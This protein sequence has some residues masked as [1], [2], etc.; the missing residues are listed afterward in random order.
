MTHKPRIMVL[1]LQ[2]VVYT[3]IF[4]ILA[5]VLILLLF[6]M[7]RPE[8]EEYARTPVTTEKYT[9]G[10]YTS[11]LSLGDVVLDVEVTV[12]ADHINA[13]TLNN[14]SETVTTMYP[15]VEPAVEKLE[16]Q[17]LRDQSTEHITWDDNGKYTAQVLLGAIEKALQIAELR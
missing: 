17:I 2:E 5:I 12:D 6:L 11:S 3:G 13:I 16:E 10:V 4:L 1:K 9:A 7:F 8:K 15:L 14:L